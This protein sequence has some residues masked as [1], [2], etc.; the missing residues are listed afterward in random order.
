MSA[1]KLHFYLS[2]LEWVSGG[3]S[4]DLW[5][6]PMGRSLEGTF[7]EYSWLPNHLVRMWFQLALELWLGGMCNHP[8]SL[9]VV[10]Y[11]C[12]TNYHKLS[13]LKQ[14]MIIT[15]QFLWVRGQAWLSFVLCS[16]ISH[17]AA[18]KCQLGM[19]GSSEDLPGELN[20]NLNNISL[21]GSKLLTY[22]SHMFCPDTH[23]QLV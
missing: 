14:H 5:P 10:I 13:E 16:M 23:S 1:N 21:W 18:I 7:R 22:L 20:T 4:K 11:C 2:S 9:P 19:G 8:C 15:S 17:K 6:V 12:I 3:C